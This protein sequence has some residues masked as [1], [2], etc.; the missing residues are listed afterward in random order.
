[1]KHPLKLLPLAIVAMMMTTACKT[2]TNVVATSNEVQKTTE[3][4]TLYDAD[5]VNWTYAH[6]DSLVDVVLSTTGNTRNPDDTREVYRSIGYDGRN[7]PRYGDAEDVLDSVVLC[8]LIDNAKAKGLKS[9]VLLSGNSGAGKTSSIKLNPD[10]YEMV[11]KAGIVLDETFAKKKKLD[12]MLARLK[13][14]GFTDITVIQVYN[15]PLQSYKNIANRY[16]HNGRAIGYNYLLKAYPNLEGRV[17]D[18]EENHQDIRRIYINNADNS[19]NTSPTHGLCT[20]EEALKWSY[21][22]DKE[23]SHEMLEFIY[24]FCNDHKLSP[25][26]THVMLYNE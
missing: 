21:I 2:N 14:E 6:M 8:R 15:T 16:L 26:D 12:A 22:I 25:R 7:V 20:A 17:K 18:L 9:A 24:N 1:M 13:S 4:G 11:Q 10:I 23:T 19:S 5:A 3:T